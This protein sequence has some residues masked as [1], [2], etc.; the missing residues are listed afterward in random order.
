MKYGFYLPTRGPT[1]EPEALRQMAMEAERLGFTSVMVADHVAIPA[2]IESAYPYTVGGN[3]LSEE[4]ALEQLTLMTFVAAHTERLR[5]VSSILIV[6]Q[7]NPVLT[8]KAIATLD[9]LSRGR[10]TV[11]VGVGWMREE[12]EALDVTTFDHRGSVTNEYLQIFKKLWTQEVT[13]HDGRFYK[14]DALRFAPKPLQTPH[15][16]IWIGGHSDA[17]LKRVARHADGWHP[18]GATAASPLPPDEVASKRAFIIEEAERHGRD[19]AGVYIAYKA[20]IYDGGRAPEGQ[21]RRPFSGSTDAIVDDIGAYVR[22]GVTELVFDFRSP[23]LDESLERMRWF[24]GE[25]MPRT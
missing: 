25:I 12:F 3:F 22:S 24:A 18:V 10:V 9:W 16:P 8:A 11:G 21:S 13:T 4:E 23:T 1:A 17:A 14:F 20:P 6:P 15:P 7:R 2:A 5:L 19:L